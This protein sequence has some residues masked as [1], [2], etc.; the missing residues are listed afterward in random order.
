M[1]FK[2]FR[3]RGV[4][5]ILYNQP[6][7]KHGSLVPW[8]WKQYVSLKWWYPPNR[9]HCVITQNTTKWNYYYNCYF[10]YFAIFFQLFRYTY[11][12]NWDLPHSWP[13]HEDWKSATCICP[14][15]MEPHLQWTAWVDLILHVP[16]GSDHWGKS[17]VHH[18]T[19][20]ILV[21]GN[22]MHR[23]WTWL[24]C[25]DTPHSRLSSSGTLEV[26][27][28]VSSH[29]KTMHSLSGNNFWM[30]DAFRENSET[31]NYINWGT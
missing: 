5:P 19:I 12:H 9:L 29:Y 24:S 30:E 15:L 14:H 13:R 3:I 26:L 25:P 28:S 16:Y 22:Q 6:P 2:V 18:G 21:Q 7:S 10:Q 17:S 1:N 20:Q 27:S 31:I 4:L 11:S 8:R 23:L